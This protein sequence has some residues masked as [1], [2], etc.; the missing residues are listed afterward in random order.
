MEDVGKDAVTFSAIEEKSKFLLKKDGCGWV[1][2]AT[3]SLRPKG[4]IKCR[5]SV[6]SEA[7]WWRIPFNIDFGIE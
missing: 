6:C 7:T 5:C 2:Q 1:K 4:A 3:E